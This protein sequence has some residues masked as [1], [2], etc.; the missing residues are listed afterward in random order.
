MRIEDIDSR[1][2]GRK[3]SSS[4]SIVQEVASASTMKGQI[5]I[6]Q[7]V[8]RPVTPLSAR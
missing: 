8:Y 1:N 4:D 3:I 2:L 6:N 5:K 7:A